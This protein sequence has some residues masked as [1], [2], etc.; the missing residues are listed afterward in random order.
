[1]TGGIAIAPTSA[2][3]RPGATAC[4]RPDAFT[5]R[6]IYDELASPSGPFAET[7]YANEADRRR[8]QVAANEAKVHP[9]PPSTRPSLSDMMKLSA[10]L[11]PLGPSTAPF[12]TTF[13]SFERGPT[14]TAPGL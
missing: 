3:R 10:P 2:A 6:V 11:A 13:P 12:P 7:A 14:A 4:A 8:K 5:R 1:M 9:G